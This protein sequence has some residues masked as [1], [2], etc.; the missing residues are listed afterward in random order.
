VSYTPTDAGRVS[1]V[2][3][4]L[5]G[6]PTTCASS[7]SYAPHGRPAGMTYGPPTLAQSWKYD[8]RLRETEAEALRPGSLMRRLNP[9]YDNAGNGGNSGQCIQRETRD[10]AFRYDSLRTSRSGAHSL[11]GVPHRASCP[12]RLGGEEFVKELELHA[13]RRLRPHPVGR[14]K[15]GPA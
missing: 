14:P 5:A 7:I 3:G 11:A 2:S 8:S 1:Q 6:V 10:S 13:G 9:A 15:T 4:L 12:P